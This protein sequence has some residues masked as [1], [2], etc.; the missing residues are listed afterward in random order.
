ME[1]TD[2][3]KKQCALNKIII[4]EDLLQD[5]KQE[6]NNKSYTFSANG[7]NVSLVKRNQLIINEKLK[8]IIEELQK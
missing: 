8:Q 7:F 6:I 1:N 3:V 2:V 4:I 5:I